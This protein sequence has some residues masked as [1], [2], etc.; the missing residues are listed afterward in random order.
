MNRRGKSAIQEYGIPPYVDDS[1]R[2]EPDFESQF[3]SISA[4][5]RASKFAPR[6]K[7]SD[8]VIYITVKG[9]YH[10]HAEKHWRLTAILEV[11]RRFKSHRQA[12]KWYEKRGIELPSN[13]MVPGNQPLSLNRTS[14]KDK[15]A[16]VKRWDVFY[17]T[18]T[19]ENSV[20]LVCKA[21]FLELNNPPI[22]TKK[23][24]CDAFGRVR[25]TQNPPSIS[26]KEY[27]RL[28]STVA[29]PQRA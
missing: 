20:F 13:C 23:T 22:V 27:Q 5:C 16:S 10:G 9:K 6:L 14:N 12:A 17:R 1:I 8:T 24:L 11:I 26:E 18:R 3:P 4:I 25:R 21:M 15:W 28:T 29:I 2:R 7:E 19:K